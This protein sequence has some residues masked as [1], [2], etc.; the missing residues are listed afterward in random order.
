MPHLVAYLVHLVPSYAHF[1]RSS[2]IL[3]QLGP[4]WSRL[5]LF[6]TPS[7][8]LEPFK[9]IDFPNVF[10]CF[11]SWAFLA[12]IS[13]ILL[14]FG[15]SPPHFGLSWGSLGT[16]LGSSWALL[17]PS[18]AL[19]WP[20]WGPLGRHCSHLGAILPHLVAYLVHLEPSYAHLGR[21]SL[22]LAQLSLS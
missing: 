18:W 9:N 1:S 12:S 21:T 20:S 3:A 13:H 7:E 11:S 8:S 16:L 2:L 5:G 15:S 19:V 6:W 10:Q 17:G 4:S 14:Y 22:I